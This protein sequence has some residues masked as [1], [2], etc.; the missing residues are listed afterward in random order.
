M[1]YYTIY[2]KRLNNGMGY[3]DVA[4]EDDQLLK[5][6]EQYLDIGVRPH[7]SYRL[8]P[9]PGTTDG[10]G[11]F[12]LDMSEVTAITTIFKD[13]AATEKLKAHV[14]ARKKYDTGSHTRHSAR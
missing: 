5:D 1:I 6:F 10:N 13:K 12:T 3:I 9:M 11:L 8:A 4:L 7:R 2:V 14:D